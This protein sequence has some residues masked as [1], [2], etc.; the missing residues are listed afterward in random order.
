MT[1]LRACSKC[2]RPF[3][4]RH[5]RHYHC[6]SCERHGNT[7]RSP[8]TQTRPTSSSVRA[9][10]RAE[11]LHRDPY[12]TLRLEGCEGASTVADHIVPAAEG[13]RYE[14][15][16]LRGACDHCNSVLGGHQAA[17]TQ[18]SSR[19]GSADRSDEP[20]ISRGGAARP[21]QLNSRLR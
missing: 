9:R 3:T 19:T 2:A 14:P 8:T 13:G 10:I 20:P 1:V 6:E 18:P 15:A 16:N 12:C 21:G 17:G 7:H 5:G 11:V 4:P